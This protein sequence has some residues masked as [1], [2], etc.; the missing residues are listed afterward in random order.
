MIRLII[1]PSPRTIELPQDYQL[2][3]GKGTVLKNGKDAVLFAYGPV[4]L[5]EALVAG[6]ILAEKNFSLK[7]VNLPWLNRI[8]LNWLEETVGDQKSIYV[9]DNH[10]HYGG[11]G[12]C[13]LNTAMRSNT[14]RSRRVIKFAV[15]QYPACGTPLETLAYHKLDGQNLATRILEND[16]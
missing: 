8:D 2:S 10:M 1:S 5:N 3:F 13:L 11:L 15:E 4:L 6:E 16:A 9:L 12:D 7:I 14:L